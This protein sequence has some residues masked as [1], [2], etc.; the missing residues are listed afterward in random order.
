MSG[1]RSTLDPGKHLS[2]VFWYY[3]EPR[4]H[5][6]TELDEVPAAARYFLLPDKSPRVGVAD[7]RFA[8]EV[9]RAPV[10]LGRV[11]DGDNTYRVSTRNVGRDD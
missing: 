9:A 4:V 5:Y 11:S 8:Q 10:L 3:L 1:E 6:F 7:D 2:P